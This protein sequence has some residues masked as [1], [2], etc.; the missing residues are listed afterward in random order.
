[1][2][3]FIPFFFIFLFGVLNARAD[4]C[5]DSSVTLD[6]LKEVSESVATQDDF[7]K[8][9]AKNKERFNV[10]TLMRS[11][12][13]IPLNAGISDE[14]P[15]PLLA[16]RDGSVVIRWSC[17]PG[18]PTSYGIVDA[19]QF[20]GQSDLKKPYDVVRLDF[21]KGAQKWQQSPRDCLSCHSTQPLRSAKLKDFV[22]IWGNYPL[23][24]GAIGSH[25]D[26]LQPQTP[27]T[28]TK[29][30]VDSDEVVALKEKERAA[31]RNA[32]QR[33]K[34]GDPCYAVLPWADLDLESPSPYATEYKGYKLNAR[35]NFL[36]S[37]MFA[38]QALSRSPLPQKIS[39]KAARA[40]LLCSLIPPGYG[41][42]RFDLGCSRELSGKLEKF[43]NKVLTE[44][45]ERSFFPSPSVIQ[46]P[47]VPLGQDYEPG[48]IGPLTYLQRRRWMHQAI[49]RHSKSGELLELLE[50]APIYS[51]KSHSAIQ[52]C[53]SVM[54]EGNERFKDGYSTKTCD[55]YRSELIELGVW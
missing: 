11:S 23:W 41:G 4:Q 30:Y 40:Q 53:F 28:T 50:T 22:P 42:K 15:G 44:Q 7:M 48:A 54:F 46:A 38:G 51:K 49:S 35:P 26:F 17:D 55:W 21:R 32:K 2:K 10:F 25:D 16:S 34:A 47:G 39:G 24:K 20:K 52:G 5:P 19:F 12:S 8:A 27:E 9:L 6:W 29:E 1:M 3:H 18:Q 31:L 36:F 37:M 13:A 43:C 33:A 14:F 45:W